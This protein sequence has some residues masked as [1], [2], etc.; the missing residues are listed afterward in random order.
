MWR[1]VAKVMLGPAGLPGAADLFFENQGD[2]TFKEATETFGL[3]DATKRVRLRRWWPPTTTAT[4]GPTSSWPTTPTPTSS[5][6]TARASG[7][8]SVGLAA[9]V[10]LNADG[11]AQAG[12]GADSGDF[13]GDGRLDFALTTF[14]FD[15]NSLY[16]NL[17]DGAFEDVSQAAGLA[18]TTFEDMSWGAG[19][20]RRR[21]RR[22]PRPL[23]RQRPPLPAGRRAPRAPGELRAEGPDLRERGRALP[24]RVGHG[25]AG[26]RGAE[27]QPRRSRSATS[28]TTAIPDLVVSAMDEE[29]DAAREH[30]AERQPLARD[31]G[32]ADGR[33]SASP[34]G[35][36]SRSRPPAAGSRYA[37]SAPAAATSRRTTSAPCSGSVTA[38]GQSPSRC[39]S[40]GSAGASPAWPSTATS[41]LDPGRRARV[42]AVGGAPRRA[43][44]AARLLAL[45]FSLC[46]PLSPCAAG[47]PAA[48][49]PGGASARRRASRT[50]TGPTLAVSESLQP[51][52]DEIDARQRPVPRRAGGGGA[53]R[54]PL[55]AGR[56]AEGEPRPRGARRGPPPG[57]VV[58]GRPPSAGRGGGGRP[59]CPPSRS[60]GP[61]TMAQDLVLDS[62]SFAR[63]L[64]QLL[65][66]FRTGH[67]RRV[68]G[69]VARRGREDRARDDRRALRPRRPG[70][71][72]LARRAR[73]ASGVCGGDATA[74]GWR[75]V[76][77][78][79]TEHRPQP[80]RGP[81]LR[82]GHDGRP[83]G[84]R[85]LPPPAQHRLRR[86]GRHAGLGLRP[87]LERPPRRLGRGRRRRRPRRHLRRPAARLPQPALPGPGR[88]HLRGR[89]GERGPRHPRGHAAVALR[90]RGQRRRPGPGRRHQHG[91]G[92]LPQRRRGPVRPR[93]GRLPL[94][95]GAPGRAHVDGD[96]RLRPRRLPRPLPV[97]LLLLLRRGRGARPA[98]PRPTTTPSTARPTCSSA[99]TATAASSRSPAR[100]AS[101]R[102]TTASA[103]PPP[104]ATTTATAGP[105]WW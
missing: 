59:A 54:A 103:S 51:F 44:S 63:E 5:T 101:T 75:V 28:T 48:A 46:R 24:R 26:A 19:V 18:A 56:E 58:P 86:L 2:G 4:G 77:W 94:R 85:L 69:H 53:H 37:R 21:P 49:R 65:E 16:R 8:E 9:G 55:G 1:G 74:S 20:P 66:D 90:R 83:R 73:R 79:A 10:A 60:S 50:A 92:A 14:A 82:R 52:L 104:G 43:R 67:G 11:R 42:R 38:R 70:H 39:A 93:P 105:T 17:G 68:P 45:A 98:R 62:R 41:R 61:G 64:R 33:Q 13:D 84:K 29:P 102:G 80:R 47:A 57:A 78:T 23:L 22:R 72:R 96:G 100:R 36:G 30:P 40:A 6:A 35:R 31:R 87:R 95:E 81:G 12:M 91:T 27:V 25:R 7:F 34:S 15:H 99:T 97:R 89:D 88:R 3:T 71:G 32:E 76:E